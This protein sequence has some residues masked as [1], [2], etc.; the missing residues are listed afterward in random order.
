[1][2]AAELGDAWDTIWLV[3][4]LAAVTSDAAAAVVGAGFEPAQGKRSHASAFDVRAC[5]AAVLTAA[6][7][8]SHLIFFRTPGP[9]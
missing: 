5:A 1:M 4:P 9:C 3:L 7:S 6:A 2:T 8:G